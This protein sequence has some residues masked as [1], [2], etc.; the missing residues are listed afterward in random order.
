M[1]FP[2]VIFLEG[3]FKIS[4]FYESSED[5]TT[6]NALLI[7]FILYR[8][9]QQGMV[10]STIIEVVFEYLYVCLVHIFYEV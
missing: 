2:T 9:A 8:G 5:H 7:T 3:K 4:P 6:Q 10:V 1:G